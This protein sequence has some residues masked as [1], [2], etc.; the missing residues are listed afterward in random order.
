MSH[1]LASPKVRAFVRG[2]YAEDF[3]F[4][5]ADPALAHL[6]DKATTLSAR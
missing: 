5:A 1:V 4:F 6:A 3:A 2:L